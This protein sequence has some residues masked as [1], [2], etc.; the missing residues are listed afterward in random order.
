[1]FTFRQA[2]PDDAG[3]IAQ[4][5]AITSAG[6]VGYLFNGLIPGLP[7]EDIIAAAFIKGQAPYETRNVI[8]SGTSDNITSLLFMYPS[9]EHVVPVLMESFLSA[10]R[11]KAVRPILER[12][13]PDSL[14]INTFWLAEE[15]RGGGRS[16][17][18]MEEAKSRCR[19]L[20]FDRISLFCWND[21]EQAL[22]FYAR[23]GFTIVEHL[24]PEELTIEGH[25]RGGAILCL[26]LGKP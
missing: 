10:K 19:E 3:Q 17:A 26:Y 16:A 13:V 6:V 9:A 7:G 4:I 12:S 5:I 2:V 22:R 15:F 20:G 8:L 21:N 24:P 25:S 18:L 14:Y 1:M 11:L 23:E